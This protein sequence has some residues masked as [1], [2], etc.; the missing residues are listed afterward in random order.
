[1]NSKKHS[2]ILNERALLDIT[3]VDDVLSFD[4]SLISLS[5]GSEVLNISGSSLSIKKLSLENGEVTVAGNVSAIVY[6]EEQP[7]RS[8]FGRRR[9]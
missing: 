5:V 8:V 2:L 7:R 6:F 9:A 4:E 1:M 3:A